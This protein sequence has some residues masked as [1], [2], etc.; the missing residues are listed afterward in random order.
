MFHAIEP[1]CGTCVRE[2]DAT[3]MTTIAH[4]LIHFLRRDARHFQIVF[5]TTFLVYGT[6][7]LQWETEWARYALLL[8]TCFLVQAFFIRA[9]GLPWHSL[10]S[11]AITGLGL[12][13][14]FHAD[15][16]WVLVLGAAIAIAGKFLI[17]VRGK[18]VFNP[19][20]FGIV[21][22][23][24]LTGDAWVSP[25]QWG[26]GPAL[27]FLVGAAGLTVLLRVGR[28]DTS[29]A[30]FATFAALDLCRT[31]LYLGWGTDVWAHR[32]M[33]G[34]LLLFTFFMITDPMTTPNSPWA[35]IAW[36]M[37]IAVITFAM[38][39]FAF[40][41]TAA[42]WALC[43]VCAITPILDALAGGERFAWLPGHSKS[44]L[45]AA[46]GVASRI[47]QRIQAR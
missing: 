2:H 16:A 12:S 21:A 6:L 7:E 38:G 34:S 5:L 32:M 41:H 45:H 4:R 10:K 30:F 25:G 37:L 13:V 8:G 47:E 23:I 20:N 39:S 44:P 18:H 9:K 36:S 26:S 11:A 15:H 43:L 42:I 29:I 33:N 17:R 27:V 3:L 22:T 35:R 46:P 31:V 14:L 24:L 19:G 28:I 40:V 1:S